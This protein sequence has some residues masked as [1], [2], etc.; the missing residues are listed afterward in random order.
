MDSPGFEPGASPVLESDHCRCFAERWRPDERFHQW[1]DYDGTDESR[2]SCTGLLE[3]PNRFRTILTEQSQIP[4]STLH[5]FDIEDFHPNDGYMEAKNRPETRTP[6]KNRTLGEREINLNEDVIAVLPGWIEINHPKVIDDHGR[7][8]LF[9]TEHGRAHKTT[10]REHIYRITRPATIRM[11]GPFDRD[12]TDCEATQ[13]RLA[14]KC[15]GSVSPHAIR[16][17][18]I[19]VH[20]NKGWPAKAVSDRTDVSQEVLDK[21]YD[22]GSKTDKRKRR[23]PFLDKL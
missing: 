11:I 18:S 8:P 2:R 15:P 22:K 7:H 12:K 3:R 10:L 13:N 23:E 19:T 6:L 5:G 17:G 14:S 20:R 4:L 1:N 16:K 9:G 21:H